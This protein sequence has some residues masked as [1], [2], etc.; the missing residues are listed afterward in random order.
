MSRRRKVRQPPPSLE[1]L[2]IVVMIIVAVIW[3]VSHI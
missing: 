1:I 2:S 3:V